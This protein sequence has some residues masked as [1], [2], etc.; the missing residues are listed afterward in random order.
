MLLFIVCFYFN[1]QFIAG[2]QKHD[3]FLY[4]DFIFANLPNSLFSSGR[5]SF[6]F[7]GI[8]YLD[9]TIL[10]ASTA[11]PSVN[12][13]GHSD[14]YTQGLFSLSESPPTSLNSQR[15]S[16]T[17]R[18]L[19]ILPMGTDRGTPPPSCSAGHRAAR[20]PWCP[21]STGRSSRK[22][23]TQVNPGPGT[24]FQQTPSVPPPEEVLGTRARVEAWI[25]CSFQQGLPRILS[26][27]FTPPETPSEAQNALSQPFPP[28]SSNT[29]PT[30]EPQLTPGPLTGMLLPSFKGWPAFIL[31]G[32]AKMP[33]SLGSRPDCLSV[34]GF[35]TPP[36]T[37]CPGPFRQLPHRIQV[38][39][40][41]VGLSWAGGSFRTEPGPDSPWASHSLTI[42]EHHCRLGDWMEDEGVRK[43]QME[44]WRDECLIYQQIN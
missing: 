4:A 20:P 2:T 15:T 38:R 32:K 24:R 43:E 34:L 40:Y 5:V 29:F 37:V 11:P 12:T 26:G 28:P 1:S 44:G 35:I 41:W 18:D 17:W 25:W 42:N 27:L 19:R 33:P 9:N 21:R 10:S 30:L 14:A 8:F 39:W 31:I 7:F 23:T 6:R 16:P 36:L 13:R 3:W 22:P